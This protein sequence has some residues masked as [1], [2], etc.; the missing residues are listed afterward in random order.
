MNHN[1]NHYINLLISKT[2][3]YFSKNI[4]NLNHSLNRENC[5][6]GNENYNNSSM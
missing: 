1:N 5:S 2:L 6:N 4:M 3:S